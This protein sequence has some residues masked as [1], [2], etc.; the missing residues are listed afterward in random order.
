MTCSCSSVVPVLVSS[1]WGGLLWPCGGGLFFSDLP[2]AVVG[3]PPSSCSYWSR[4]GSAATA[5]PSATSVC[6]SAVRGRPGVSPGPGAGAACSR[7]V[8][9]SHAGLTAARWV[10]EWFPWPRQQETVKETV[11]TVQSVL[12]STRGLSRYI[13]VL[14][15]L[16]GA[17]VP[18]SRSSPL[19]YYSTRNP[20]K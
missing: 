6:C 4:D 1:L 20:G 17:G 9:S 5:G 7:P 13:T 18:F 2:L 11:W 12:G 19:Q 3:N 8:A 15:T 14:F 10:S 16:R